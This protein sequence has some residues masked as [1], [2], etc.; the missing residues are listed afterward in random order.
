MTDNEALAE[1][2]RRWGYAARI[3]RRG[4]QGEGPTLFAVGVRK[5]ALF[6]LYGTGDSW[7]EAFHEAGPSP[8]P[9][10]PKPT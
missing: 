8:S 2:R 9:Q 4:P 6:A 10:S 3:R 7:E 1:A 5:E